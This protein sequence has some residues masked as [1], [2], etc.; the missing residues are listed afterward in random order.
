MS[1]L[2]PQGGV[3]SDMAPGSLPGITTGPD[4]DTAPGCVPLWYAL[5][6]DN[7]FDPVAANALLAEM[8]SILVDREF[9]YDCTRQ[10]NLSKALGPHLIS[11]EKSVPLPQDPFLVLNGP[12]RTVTQGSFSVPNTS[13]RAI[14]ALAIAQLTTLIR[15]TSS[16]ENLDVNMTLSPDNS[17]TGRLLY[18][19]INLRNLGT[20]G[21]TYFSVQTCKTNILTI[22]PGGR[23]FY[24]RLSTSASAA[25]AWQLK[26][27]YE[28]CKWRFFG[29]SNLTED[30]LSE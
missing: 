12:D 20:S 16:G 19:T 21:T 22:P 29:I 26:E 7:N 1:S 28:A 27:D 13:G 18:A 2:F 17:F 15:E 5:R 9:Q 25:N 8:M 4:G 3:N 24:Y 23:T 14:R 10:D 30:I 11:Y 6:C